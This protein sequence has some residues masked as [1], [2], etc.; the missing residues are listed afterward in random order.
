MTIGGIQP[1]QEVKVTVQLLKR[2]E[3]EAGAYALRIPTAYFIKFGNNN[4]EEGAKV[5]V[6]IPKQ[7]MS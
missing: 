3:I 4:A 7:E 6:G 1:A 5:N 2:L